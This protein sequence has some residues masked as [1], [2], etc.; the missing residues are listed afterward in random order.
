MSEKE[1][2]ARVGVM[3]FLTTIPGLDNS[4]P[5]ERE[6]TSGFFSHHDDLE[7]VSAPRCIVQLQCR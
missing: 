3:C 7:S 2:R 6:P 1:V 4:L 5:P